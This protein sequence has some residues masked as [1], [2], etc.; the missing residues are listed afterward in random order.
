MPKQLFVI[1]TQA[2]S[3]S[4]L[5]VDLLNQIPGVLCHSEIFKPHRLEVA[6]DISAQIRWTIEDRDARPIRCI[7]EILAIGDHTATGF[8]LFPGHNR[9]LLRH[10][11]VA[12]HIHKIVLLR[13]PISR[14]IS[15]LRAEKTGTWVQPVTKSELHRRRAAG[16]ASAKPGGFQTLIR[17]LSRLRGKATAGWAQPDTQQP[18]NTLTPSLVFEAERFEHFIMHHN[19]FA[20]ET[21]RAAAANPATYTSVDY[22]EV[23]SL[24][25]LER[26]CPV[27]GV[28]PVNTSGILPSLQKQTTEPF[29]QLI[30]NYDEMRQY[31][32]RRHPALLE[33]AGCPSLD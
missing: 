26:I 28:G 19:K 5:L 30:S 22:E 20:A 24:R 27:L 32:N 10:I 23:V 7:R 1:L 8:K 11:S 31:L 6:K 17:R 2:R 3:G 4:Y 18:P 21:S 14:F 16:T 29:S 33:Q 15:R 13:H 12:K 25:A 9:R